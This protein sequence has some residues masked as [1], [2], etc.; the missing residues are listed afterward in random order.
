MVKN[1]SPGDRIARIVFGVAAVATV[2]IDSLSPWFYFGIILWVTGI[3][4]W[5]PLY[6]LFRLTPG[7]NCK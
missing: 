6:A 3:A 5:C 1:I 2:F 4:G 7:K